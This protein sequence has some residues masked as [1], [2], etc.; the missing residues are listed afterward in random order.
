MKGKQGSENGI[1]NLLLGERSSNRRL[2]S[3]LFTVHCSLIFLLLFSLS[4]FSQDLKPANPPILPFQQDAMR[5]GNEE[6]LA[7]QYYQSREYE[8]A[9]EIFER[10]YEQK[11]SPYYFQYLLLCL[12]ETKEYGKAE[13][14]VKKNMKADPDALRYQVDLG[15]IYS[16]SGN[17]EK[18]KK[19]YDEALKKLGPNQQ[20]IFDLAN[21]F[22]TKGENEYAIQTYLKGRQL[23]KNGYTFGF[24]IA[25]I[26]ERMGDFKNTMEEYL[27]LLEVN[28][29]Y[30]PTVQDRIQVILSYDVNNEKNESLRKILLARAQKN[31]D[32]TYYA[33]LL[34]WY[35]IQQKDFNL[36]L[37]QAKSLDRRLNENGEK[38]VSLANLAVS[39]ENYDI[40]IECYQYLVSKGPSCSYY[41]YSRR[42]LVNTRYIK[43]ISEPVPLKKELE[44]IEKEFGEELKRSEDNPENIPVI[45]NL[46]HVQA[47]YLEKP[48]AAT[49][50]L[51]YAIGM[52]GV[53]PAERAKCK[54]E[55]ADIL[56]FTDDVWQATLLYQQAYQDFKNDVLGQEAKFKNAKLS[57]YI[58]EFKWAQAQADVLKA[59]TSKFISNDAIALSLLISENFDPDS[60]TVALGMYARADL[61]DYRNAENQALLSLDSI[62][63]QFGDHP[64]L[65]HVLYKKAEIKRKQGKYSEADSLFTE[66]VKEYPDEILADEALM[67]SA[68]LNEKQLNNPSKAMT[69]YME[70]LDKYPGSIFVPDAR[71]K[72]RILRG[73]NK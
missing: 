55:L 19:L 16:R 3:S 30:L 21:A 65:Q 33:E 59:A 41:D 10:L 38:L 39:N 13:R 68:A 64:I 44:L 6:P 23:V 25:G 29:S 52:A 60:N 5:P 24:E 32:K 69:L 12:V 35:S 18:S 26:Y 17:P 34:W 4:A 58:G 43:I 51:E 63:H 22:I 71:R 53:P 2:R 20:Q 15:Y 40:A 7:I 11:P 54:I 56:L 49:T 70:L 28:T 61:L 1:G 14:L 27:N 73:D 50:L 45:R 9:A 72:Y 31:P 37:L 48:E 46:A 57:F 47:F 36:A 42:E 62:A 67:Q 8:K 66:L